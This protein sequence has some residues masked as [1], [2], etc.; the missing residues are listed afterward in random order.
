MGG[1]RGLVGPLAAQA[2]GGGDA[3]EGLARLGEAVDRDR[4]V[5]V[6][7]TNDDD[8]SH[9]EL[10]CFGGVGRDKVDR[11]GGLVLGGRMRAPGRSSAEHPWSGGG[12]R[13]GRVSWVWTMIV[14]ALALS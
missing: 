8:A 9:D 3:R 6:D 2:V 12:T 1:R 13:K 4:D 5:L 14:A 11:S 7:G 10:L